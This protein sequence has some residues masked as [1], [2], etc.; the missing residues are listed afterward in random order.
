M[1]ETVDEINNNTED[2]NLYAVF[3]VV[4]VVAA[5]ANASASAVDNGDADDYKVDC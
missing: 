1:D 4:V 2:F 3:V 5:A